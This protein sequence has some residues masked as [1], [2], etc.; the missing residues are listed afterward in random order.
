VESHLR[1]RAAV[2]LLGPSPA[3]LRVRGPRYV[4]VDVRA[5]VAFDRGKSAARVEADVRAQLARFLHPLTGGPREGRPGWEFGR[6]PCLSDVYLALERVA[7]VDHVADLSLCLH[8]LAPAGGDAARAE[9]VL[10]T[11][12]H[13]LAVP[14]P[15][16]A[17]VCDG[18]GHELRLVAAAP[19]W[20]E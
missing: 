2:P 5:T 8:G 1:E 16:D 19:R 12:D 11:E 9:D 6:A 15:G 14:V 4:P 7:G 3:W 17:L 20:Q 18:G 10:V 13:P